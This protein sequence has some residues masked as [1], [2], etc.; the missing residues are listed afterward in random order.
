MSFNPLSRKR[1]SPS[2]LLVVVLID[3]KGV[4]QSPFEEKVVSIK[5]TANQGT[6][7]IIE[8]QS[9]FE[10]KVVSIVAA[11][12][13]NTRLSYMFQSPFEEKVVS[14]VLP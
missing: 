9:P 11:L 5:I 3:N 2:S 7:F 14:I 10:E 6:P 4:F 13:I 1:W 8:F 12:G